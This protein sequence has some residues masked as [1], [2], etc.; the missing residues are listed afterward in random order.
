MAND[1]EYI[2]IPLS[3][4]RKIIANRLLESKNSIPHYYLSVS[5]E[6]D[7]VLAI[8]S[9]L[10]KEEGIKISVNDMIVKAAALSCIKVKEVN[11]QWMDNAIR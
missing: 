4:M 3:N 7:E 11:S 9:E 6:M 2:D 8:R 10:N 1:Q 5:V